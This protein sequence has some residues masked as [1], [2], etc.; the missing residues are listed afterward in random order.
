MLRDCPWPAEVVEFQEK[1]K[2]PSIFL[3]RVNVEAI[4]VLTRGVGTDY[5]FATPIHKSASPR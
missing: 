5:S 3:I 4:M 1:R 2:Q